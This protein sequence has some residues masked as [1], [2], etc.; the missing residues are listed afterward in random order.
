VPVSLRETFISEAVD[1]FTKATKQAGNKLINMPMMRL[2]V[3]AVK[4]L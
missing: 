3:E 2:Q 4:P 1:K